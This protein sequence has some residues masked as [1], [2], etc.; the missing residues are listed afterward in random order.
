MD[1]FSGDATTGI[2]AQRSGRGY[3]GIEL[4]E[5]Y[6]QGSRERLRDDR[7]LFNDVAEPDPEAEQLTL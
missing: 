4:D 7:P 3:L 1:P 2:A 6:A 5:G